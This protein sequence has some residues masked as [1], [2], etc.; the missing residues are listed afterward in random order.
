MGV[1]NALGHRSKKRALYAAQQSC[2]Q[3]SEAS[4]SQSVSL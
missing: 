1:K 4:H 3:Q 2:S